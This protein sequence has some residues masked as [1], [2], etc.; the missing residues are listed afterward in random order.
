MKDIKFMRRAIELA[1]KGQGRTSPNPMV[2][3]VIVKNKRIIAEGWH[4]QCGAD[5]AEI[6]ALK[7]AGEGSRGAAMYVTLEPC[8]HYGRTPPC[9]DQVIESGIKELVI[10]MKDPNPLV[11]GKSLKRFKAAR[12]KIRTGVLQNEIEKINEAFI[13][14]IKFKMPFV[15]AK[16]AQTLD[17]KMATMTGDSKWITSLKTR[18][19]ARRRR[20]E[21]DA[22]CVGIKTVLKDN[23][24]LKGTRKK[25]FKKIILDSTLQIP[26]TAK[27]FR[28]SDP[29][30]C[31]IAATAK[32]DSRKLKI[33]HN[34]GINVLI[35]PEKKGHIHLRWL[36]KELA[37]R[38]IAS[39]LIEGGA[40]VIGCALKENL[41]D[42]MYVYLAPKIVGDQKALNSVVGLRI[43]KIEKA[44]RL[45]D[46]NVQK[47]G[48]DFFFTGYVVRRGQG[49]H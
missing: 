4:K 15:V 45:K 18:E 6:M 24:A 12:I 27:L 41:V 28:G 25:N 35:C 32:V 39:I 31:I 17:G 46:L 37:K 21:F 11:N 38:E 23:P 40:H 43:Q 14:Y 16:C 7:K 13:K 9:V 44:V 49:F 42:K 10:G 34:R 26:L 48:E 8:F 29:S 3:C 2:G 30:D 47:I 5:H 19:F 33:L 1:L 36:L 20:D 22:I